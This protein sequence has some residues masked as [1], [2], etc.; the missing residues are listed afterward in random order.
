MRHKLVRM[1]LAA[2]VAAAASPVLAENCAD[3]SFSALA[4]TD[5]RGAFVGNING[6]VA[7]TDYLASQWGGVWS[8]MAKSDDGGN[9]PFTSNPQVSTNGTL[10][11]DT[12]ISGMFVI[13]LKA[14]TNYSYYLF[15]ALTP[16]SSLTFDTLA[17]VALNANGMPQDLSHA[18]L[19]VG[20]FPVPEPGIAVLLTA[21]I[22]AIAFMARRRRNG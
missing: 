17:G 21:G 16:V 4:A 3:T 13:G 6:S 12:P 18:N 22:G 2:L 15:N 14:A 9:G 5:C 1:G 11:F 7:E 8:Y 19:Y 10:T 20:T